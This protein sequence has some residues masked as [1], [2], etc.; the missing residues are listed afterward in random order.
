MIKNNSK[1]IKCKKKK[2]SNHDILERKNFGR[3]ISD[4][5]II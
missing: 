1:Q 5:K 4:K 3:T 2:K